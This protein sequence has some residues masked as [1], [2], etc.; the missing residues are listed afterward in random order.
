MS[1][2][3]EVSESDQRG[4]AETPVDLA[5]APLSMQERPPLDP[6][7]AALCAPVSDS[8]P[9]GPDLD[10]AGDSD[11]LNF[12]A[13]VEGILPTSFFSLEDGKP[14]DPST[15]DLNGQL[16]ATDMLLA[17]SRDI[18]LLVIRARLLILNRDIAGFAVTVAA[19]AEWL[20]RFWDAVHP[21]GEDLAARGAAISALNLPTVIFPLQYTPLFEGRR[22]GPVTYRGWMVATGEIKPRTGDA[23]VSGSALTE[24]IANADPVV[25]AVA[26]RH[27]TL[28][29]GALAR[30][31]LAFDAH[32]DS[33]DLDSLST[34][35]GK[36]RAFIG[37]PP[38]GAD[39]A[40]DRNAEDDPLRQTR[41]T[42]AAVA[43]LTSL[44]EA[45]RALAAIAEY[46]A[47][48]EP[49]SPALPLVRQA[50]QLIGKSF[51]EIMTI[52]VPSHVEKAAFQIGTNPVFD[53]PVSK[54]SSLSAGP[55]GIDRSADADPVS[56]GPAADTDSAK[57]SDRVGSRGQALALLDSVQR[58]F[59]HAE[60]SSPVPMLCERARALAERDFMAVLADVLPKSALK[61]L[62]TDR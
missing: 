8:S 9:C 40:L 53:L 37:P 32:G 31:R 15:I 38:A 47:H 39:A 34:L 55:A 19:A 24:A 28:L 51:L 5:G 10:L 27:V 48:C 26:R 4:D 13:Q 62:N 58:Y 50:H 25:L 16:A 35:V 60:P 29:D 7:V 6:A 11:Y 14:F 21:S 36:M 41:E 46:Y 17:R 12:L 57:S 54:L 49:S 45:K 61:A 56:A 23:A 20:D 30:I 33:A 22:I 18:R 52:L 44:A 3:F 42:E 59:R 1:E 43:P 2:G